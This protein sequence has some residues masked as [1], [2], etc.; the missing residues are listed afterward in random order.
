MLY[1]TLYTQRALDHLN[2]TGAE[3]ADGDIER[4]SPLATDHITLTGPPGPGDLLL[5]AG[6][7]EQLVDHLVADPPVR[8]HTESFTDPP[9]ASSTVD[10]LIDQLRRHGRGVRGGRDPQPESL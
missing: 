9:A 8:R 5:R 7:G 6:A 10:S 2:A 3:I 4:L 1:N